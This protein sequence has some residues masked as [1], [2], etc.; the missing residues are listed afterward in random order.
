MFTFTN[1]SVGT[2]NFAT[3]E[4]GMAVTASAINWSSEKS[5]TK[6]SK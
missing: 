1:D 6:R 2:T 3:I 5:G 4:Q